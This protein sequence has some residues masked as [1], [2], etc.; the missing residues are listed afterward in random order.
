MEKLGSSHQNLDRKVY[1][2]LK[3]MILERKLVPGTKILQDKFA[4]ELGVSRTPVVNALKMLEH[5]KLITARPR[6]GF[7]VRLF[8][9]QEMI[10]IF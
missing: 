5:E 8:S 1:K 6:R 2:A 7:Y 3:T 4:R 10:H 9:T